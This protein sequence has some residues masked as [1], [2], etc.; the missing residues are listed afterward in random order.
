MD[1]VNPALRGVDIIG[2]FRCY[3]LKYLEGKSVA[4]KEYIKITAARKHPG[5]A[6]LCNECGKCETHCPQNIPIRKE[7]KKVKK[8]LETAYYKLGKLGFKL[9]NKW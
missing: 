9:I 3:N 2:S 4:V 5:S 8:E 7:L 6:S 1:T